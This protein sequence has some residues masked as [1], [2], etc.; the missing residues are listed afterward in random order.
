MNTYKEHQF[1]LQ[2]DGKIGW[3]PEMPEKPKHDV[4][5][6]SSL[7][8][9]CAEMSFENGACRDVV[10]RYDDNCP[11]RYESALQSAIASAVEVSNQVEVKMRLSEVYKDR[12]INTPYSLLCSVEKTLE[13]SLGIDS[14][15]S[16][17]AK[18]KQVALVTFP[19]SGEKKT[20]TEAFAKSSLFKK[21]EPEKK[22]QEG[23]QGGLHEYLLRESKGYTE[24]RVVVREDGSAYIHVLSRD[25]ETF[26]FK[27][28]QK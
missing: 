19:E 2:L 25:S 3:I 22:E 27:I 1:T 14:D 5:C 21:K 15:C 26:D 18:V 4:K 23:T 24:F 8:C 7:A 17:Y 28:C 9:L 13:S 16:G 20:L 6:H 11:H 12:S 10:D